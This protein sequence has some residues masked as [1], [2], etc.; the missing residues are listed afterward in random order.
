[1]QV[2][3]GI[4]YMFVEA[5]IILIQLQE[6][7]RAGSAYGQ[8]VSL[9]HIQTEQVIAIYGIIAGCLQVQRKKYLK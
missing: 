2:T 7:Y 6:E 4:L 3:G 9:Q 5:G 1:M 8:I